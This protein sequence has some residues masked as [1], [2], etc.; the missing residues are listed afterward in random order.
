[1][2]E[3]AARL[4]KIFLARGVDGIH[5]HYGV[6]PN[7]ALSRIDD[8]DRPDLYLFVE[9]EE[10]VVLTTEILRSK[11]AD[12]VRVK[13][14]PVGP[15]DMVVAL[16][17]LAKDGK[18]PVK[19]IGVLDADQPGKPGCINLPGTGSP[20]REVFI[21]IQENAV[22]ELSIRLGVQEADVSNALVNAI[23][24]IDHHEWIA[25]AAAELPSRG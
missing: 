24:R 13:C 5:I 12:L 25:A 4:P 9:D 8:V 22:K 3:F 17:A 10:A 6:S 21:T 14:M 20:E 16:G 2:E 11:K 15:A 23:A 1:M 18:L 19:A 7:Y